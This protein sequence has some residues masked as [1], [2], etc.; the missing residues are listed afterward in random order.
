MLFNSYEFLCFF[1]PLT[2]ALFFVLCARGWARGA[3]G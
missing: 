3:A 2:C 1:F